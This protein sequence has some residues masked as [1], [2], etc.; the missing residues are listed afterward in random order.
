MSQ[1]EDLLRNAVMGVGKAYGVA[2]KDLSEELAIASE[3][4][5]KVSSGLGTL[6]LRKAEEDAG[7]STF[8]LSL[9]SE[10]NVQEIAVFYVSPNGYPIKVARSERSLMYDEYEAVLQSREEINH[11]FTQAVSTPD[12]RLVLRVAFLLRQ[13]K[14][15]A[16]R[17]E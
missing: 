4:V 17:S 15:P 14:D 11:Y 9:L 10:K 6:R 1:L 5:R 16:D 7:G 13:Q 8:S 12:S 3:A 2:E